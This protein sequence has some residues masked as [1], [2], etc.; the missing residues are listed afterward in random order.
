MH[1]AH[2][3]SSDLVVEDL[4]LGHET[5]ISFSWESGSSNKCKIKVADMIHADDC[6]TI[7]WQIFYA[8]KV[9]LKAQ[10]LPDALDCDDDG[11]IN[12]ISH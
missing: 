5:Y 8:L 4:F 11:R 1:A 9:E 7:F 6:A 3:W 12:V 2:Q 10:V